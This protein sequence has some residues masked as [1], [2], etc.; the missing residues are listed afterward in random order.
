M[1]RPFGRKPYGRAAA[2]RSGSPAF[3]RSA[4]PAVT[5]H[6]WPRLQDRAC[7][8]SVPGILSPRKI[9]VKCARYAHVLRMAQA[10]HLTVTFPGKTIGIY[11]KDGA[12]RGVL[13]RLRGLGV[14][15][16]T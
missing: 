13:R 12:K 1:S 4:V 9:T 5:L 14:R 2:A 16:I 7:P 11:R 15:A 3:R 8:S 6:R 10:P